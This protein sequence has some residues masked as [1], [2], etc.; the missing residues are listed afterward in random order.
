MAILSLLIFEGLAKQL[1]PQ[2]DFQAEARPIVL[3]TLL[4]RNSAL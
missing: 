2:L 1:Y 3:Q 4:Q